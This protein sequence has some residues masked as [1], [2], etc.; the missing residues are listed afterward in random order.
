MTVRRYRV[1]EAYASQYPEP[2]TFTAGTMLTV[3]K[4]DDGPEGWHDWFFCHAPG[5]AG[6]WVPEA[7][8]G[9]IETMAPASMVAPTDT[10]P[11]HPGP[12]DSTQPPVFARALQ[13]YTARE[14]SVDVG[15]IVS[16]SRHLGGWLWADRHGTGESGWVP[17][18]NLVEA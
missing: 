15:D 10:P 6:G 8:I 1:V 18:A 12:A 17:L 16:G 11:A 9:P 4:R 14:L 13:D 3:G 2:I 5:Q 7:I